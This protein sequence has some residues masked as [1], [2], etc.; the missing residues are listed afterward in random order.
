[1]K[2]LM[3]VLISFVVLSM[4]G[5][6]AQYVVRGI[7]SDS[8]GPMIGVAVLEEGTQNGTETDID[9]KFELTVA[10]EKSVLVFMF[11]GYKDLRLPASQASIVVMEEDAEMLEESVVIG[12]GTVK[13]EDMTGSVSTVRADQINKGV[14]T[15]PSQMLAGKSAGVVVTAGSGQPGSGSTIRIRGGS[16]LSAVNDPLIVVDGLP[17]S[18]TGISGVA[19]PLASINPNDIESYTVLKD[20]SATAIYGSRASNGVIIITTKKG[21]KSDSWVPRVNVDFTSSVSQNTRYLDVMTGDEMRLAM[22]AYA[23]KDSDG[24]KALGTENTDWQKA[25]YRIGQTYEVNAGFA[26]NV[27]L[28]NAGYL[29]YRVSGGY[30][31]QQG[32][33]KTSS[34]KRGTVA[35]NLNP[36]LLDEHLTISLNG[37]N[38][39]MDNRFANQ[40]AISAAAQYDPTQPIY[41]DSANGL[42]GYRI[43]GT[44]GIPNTQS[45]INPVAALE[46]YMDVADARRFIGNAQFDYKFHGLEDLRFNLNLGLDFSKSNG[47]VDTPVGSEQS[48]HNQVEGG[49]GRHTVYD[50]LKRD[51]TL[52]A[53]L[54]YDKSLDK[55]HFGVMGGYSWQHFYTESNTVTAKQSDHNA[56]LAELHNRSE[57]FLVSFFGRANYS[58]DNR[59]ML[60]ATVRYDGTSRFINNKWGFFPSLAFA[61]NLKNESFLKNADD[62]SALKLRL[63]WGQTGQQDLNA[64]DYPAIASYYTN[65][66]GSYYYFGNELIVPITPLGYN[67][68]LKWET[69]TTYNA[70]ID[71]GFFDNRITAS[72][73]AYYRLTTDLLNYTPV[74]A[75]SNLKNYLN[76]NIGSLLNYGVEMDLNFIAFQ[77][78]DWFWRIGVNGAWNRNEITKLTTNDSDDYKGVATGGISGGVGNTIQRFM[79]GFPVNTFYVYQQVYDENG[80]PIMGAYVD[81]NGD[82]VINADDMYCYKKAAPDFTFGFNTLLQYRNWTLAVSTHANIGNYVYDNNSSNMSLLTDLWTNNFVANRI[83]GAM[84]T[85]FT[86][87]QYFSD[88]WVKNASFLKIDNITL[89]YDFKLPRNMSLNVF[90]TVQNVLTITPY[91][92]IDPEIFN[93]IDNNLWPRPRTYVLGLKFNF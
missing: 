31:D 7:V 50:Q 89:G 2:R 46:Q 21:K 49:S 77:S 42:D 30:Y 14:I 92:G 3:L 15:S 75:G 83:P 90:G 6:F 13:K 79:V 17:I 78:A 91:D 61:W 32:T 74:P 65:L 81:R 54:A 38:M 47:T 27:G 34:L 55:H 48:W 22:E 24:Y 64:G 11:I 82:G 10:S 26:G 52:E 88:Y 57:Y 72:V 84:E 33:L 66:L 4:P 35:L 20:A 73:D 68:D 12:Y 36:A 56:I 23:G 45:T 37:K 69:T 40:G 18:N 71:L 85:N 62:L 8:Y 60:T 80:K 25:I 9:G 58:Y 53:Y 43:W 28:G 67:A 19:D 59:Y 86:T 41:D 70:G 93:G 63:S 87:A 16:S 76:A 5:A 1:M 39:W 51:Q 44:N 29:P